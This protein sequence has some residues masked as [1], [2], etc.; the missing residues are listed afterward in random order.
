MSRRTWPEG[1]G[2]ADGS[3]V[4]GDASP[5][6]GGAPA[7]EPARYTVRS[8][9]ADGG[10]GRVEVVRDER[11]G[12]DV[13]RKTALG[14]ADARLAR[15]ARVAARLDHPNIVAVH[16]AGWADGRFFYT[17]RLIRGRSLGEAL[18]GAGDLEARLR[19]LRPF[20][21]A[22][23]AVAYAHDAGVVH[24]D[25]KPDNV[26]LGPFG[27]TQV[28]DW[29]LARAVDAAEPST[30]D[31]PTAEVADPVRTRVGAV[32][33]TPA[34]M[35]PEQARGE[36]ATTS[37]DV[38]GLGAILHEVLTGRPPRVD[39]R[40]DRRAVSQVSGVPAELAA[41]CERAL[42]DDPADRYPDAQ[43][44][45]GDLAAW[46]DGDRVAAYA[47][48]PWELLVR[49]AQAWRVPLALGALALLGVAA[50]LGWG[51][52]ASQ[53]ERDRALSAEAEA[54]SQRAEAERN[55]GRALLARALE[56]LDVG[57]TPEVEVFAAH[58]AARDA[59]PLALGLLAGAR[60]SGTVADRSPV[61]LL[62]CARSVLVDA[63]HVLCAADGPAQLLAR[64]GAEPV[65]SVGERV[66]GFV[67]GPGVFAVASTGK[68]GGLDLA[69]VD[70]R[71][72]AT[73]RELGTTHGPVYT[74]DD[75]FVFPSPAGDRRVAFDD[76]ATSRL[77]PSCPEGTGRIEDA[78]WREGTVA[79]V[80]DRDVYLRTEDPPGR[81]RL[82]PLPDGRAVYRVAWHPDGDALLGTDAV[83]GLY[84]WD[85]AT[86]AV[87]R[88]RVLPGAGV[89]DLRAVDGG[90]HWVATTRRGGD[91]VLDGES[92]ALRTRL[93]A[94][95]RGRAHVLPDGTVWS[96]GPSS[97]LWRL[98]A[99]APSPVR[100]PGSKTALAFGPDGALAVGLRDLD[101]VG[102]VRIYDAERRL[103]QTVPLGG[104]VVKDLAFE[105]DGAHVVVAA[106]HGSSVRVEVATGRVVDDGLP[107]GPR[108][109][110]T[111]A[112]TW[113]YGYGPS[114]A[115]VV[116]GAAS[117]PEDLGFQLNDVRASR[118]GGWLVHADPAGA[119]RRQ[120][121]GGPPAVPWA[122]DRVIYG[123][124]IADGGD[125]VVVADQTGVSVF[126]PDGAE[127]C[128]K[129]LD[130][131]PLD[132]A[133]DR[134][135][136][137]VAVGDSEGRGYLLDAE[138]CAV[139]LAF[140]GHTR[141]VSALDLSPDGRWLATAS[142]DGSTRWWDLAVL[143]A[144]P[145][146]LVREAEARWGVGLDD[147]ADVVLR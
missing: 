76:G 124:A 132:V 129:P 113:V 140:A 28:V 42:E 83:E 120:R 6:A 86:G 69:Q 45:A 41:I 57:A 5:E 26:M 71:T 89:L 101:D 142:W 115:R 78:A 11:L 105:A 47:Y 134:Q 98:T 94:A 138:D 23:E 107:S 139:L 65:W 27:E 127:R 36:E 111:Q 84:R 8:H 91:L 30:P 131:F 13:A 112:G 100:D 56:A 43:A 114:R 44:L 1:S 34:Y 17:M 22:C 147:L 40:V 74:T 141:R 130:S 55:L 59:G 67:A 136:Q 60:A 92:L 50:A 38:W 49:A 126:G 4:W 82:D 87:D 21:V 19:L 52:R 3:D 37:S 145:E 121:I 128:R 88:V 125:P 54:V 95:A 24:R 68:H 144:A 110:T 123:V 73:V 12:R 14:D 90:R 10:M 53:L 66:V 79:V 9:L 122:L 99:L 15:E 63:D 16:D 103:R 62:P 32:V 97:H 85:V 135:G 35:S 18:A 118:D 77:A 61:P 146:D 116:P 70:P 39:G 137:R 80:C 117:E 7:S 133:V 58:A 72:G 104:R 48:T 96:V 29:G 33:G 75:A 31:A 46:L 119:V 81:R 108:A 51:V 64:G 106:A 25:L 109:V 143:G 102:A 20:V 2:V 93:P